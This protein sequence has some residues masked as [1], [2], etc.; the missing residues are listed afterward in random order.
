M[1]ASVTPDISAQQKQSPGLALRWA[2]VDWLNGKLSIER[3]IIRQIV[4]DVKTDGSRKT[5][6]IAA[7]LLEALKTW[8]QKT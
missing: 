8:R 5:F 1:T 2:D 6:V 7:K 4:D 3:G